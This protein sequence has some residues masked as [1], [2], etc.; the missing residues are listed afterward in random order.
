VFVVIGILANSKERAVHIAETLGLDNVLHFGVRS[1]AHRGVD[2][3]GLLIDGAV[4]MTDALYS[5]YAP[6]LMAH[7]AHMCRVVLFGE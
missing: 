4:K 3:D 6:C 7:E 2:L 5:E 1:K